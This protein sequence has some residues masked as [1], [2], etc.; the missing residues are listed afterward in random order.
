MTLCYPSLNNSFEL[1][2]HMFIHVMTEN[3]KSIKPWWH[4][5]PQSSSIIFMPLLILFRRK[6]DYDGYCSLELSLSHLLLASTCTKL[7]MLVLPNPWKPNYSKEYTIN[8]YAWQ[9]RTIQINLH[10]LSLKPSN[11]SQFVPLFWAHEEVVVG[12]VIFHTN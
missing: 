7:K 2:W 9:F 11:T 3:K 6:H 5:L 1:T 8:T 4:I 12:L 10:L